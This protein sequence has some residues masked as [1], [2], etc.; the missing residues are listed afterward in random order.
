[1][2]ERR[3]KTSKKSVKKPSEYK[4]TSRKVTIN[5]KKCTVYLRR[6]DG[7]ECI[8]RVNKAGKVV[9]RKLAKVIAKRGGAW[10]GGM[11]VQELL[12]RVQSGASCNSQECREDELEGGAQRLDKNKKTELYRKARKYGVKGRSKMTK[13]QP[14]VAVRAAQKAI[15]ER[16][17]RR[18]GKGRKA[19]P[20]S[21]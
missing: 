6:K 3:R 7:A 19:A 14:V 9:Y 21:P 20:K 4:R 2:A 1:M 8:R 10:T 15:G 16:L 17:R 5:N 11:N 18:S 13:Q 12:A